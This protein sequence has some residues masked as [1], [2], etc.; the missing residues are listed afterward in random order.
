MWRRA[1][2]RK[3]LFTCVLVGAVSAWGLDGL[4]QDQTSAPPP[5]ADAQASLQQAPEATQTRAVRLSDVHGTVQVLQNGEAFFD[6]AR[7]NMPVVQ[8][9]KFVTSDDGRAEIQFE[10][11]SVARIAPNSSLTITKLS[12]N[13][14]GTTVTTM[15]ADTGLTYYELD[16]NGGIYSVRFGE[17][18]ITPNDGSIFR[19]DLD[20]T[21]ELAVMHGSVHIGNSDG[22]SAD[23]NTNQSARFDSASPN[24]YQL[25][26][27]V[28]ANSWDQWN[29]DRD[30]A[31]AELDQ[32]ATEARADTGTPNNPA[33]SD[34]DA[35]GNWYNVPGYGLGWTPSGVGEDW[36]PYGYGYWGY[37]DGIGYTW[38][39]GYSWGW[40]PY[41][42][43]AWSWFQGFGWMWFPGNCGWAG[44]AF[45]GGGLG[46][47]YG[48]GWYPYAV[49]WTV[50]AGYHRPH[51]PKVFHRPGHRRIPVEPMVAV[52]R[53]PKF[54]HLFRSVGVRTAQPRTLQ[55][56]G[57][58]IAPIQRSI[59]PYRGGPLGEG[60]SNTMERTNPGVM[61]RRAYKGVW[62]DPNA[63]SGG[64]L[65]YRPGQTQSPSPRVDG[66]NPGR[67]PV[68]SPR[69]APVYR[70]P[71]MP[72][73]FGRP[74]GP[75][76]VRPE[77]MRAP[78][79]VMHA[80]A[81]HPAGPSHR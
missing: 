40:W 21:P 2:K 72:G 81:A 71:S 15:E 36:D 64:H 20:S 58:S 41:R 68:Y 53:N 49:I 10:D 9:M 32:N 14:D 46:Y 31:L 5:P 61:V 69:P 38:I 27:S 77:P 16:S 26:E 76:A 7:L 19:L 65:V 12:R 37:Y 1:L 56:E 78:P 59:H 48:Y 17:D 60:F 70:A 47:G 79:P 67:A 43:G 54:K 30:E 3:L 42:C 11:G 55:F 18:S 44:A 28:T 39:S 50:P 74:A 13:A 52:D 23:I 8:G 33:W 6:Q 62:Y 24:E 22:L 63:G 4:A 45:G 25:L 35:Y 29:S 66:L 75:P 51:R 57:K 80:P 34:L 73:N